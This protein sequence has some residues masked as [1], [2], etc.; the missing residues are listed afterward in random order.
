[1][2]AWRELSRVE[3]DQFS[4]ELNKARSSMRRREENVRVSSQSGR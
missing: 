4:L 1:M 3:L 2:F